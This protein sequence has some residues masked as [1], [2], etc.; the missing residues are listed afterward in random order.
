[1]EDE[2]CRQGSHPRCCRDEAAASPPAFRAR[3]GGQAAGRRAS[4]CILEVYD[5]RENGFL[6]L[7]LIGA[8]TAF[9]RGMSLKVGDPQG[10][11]G[12]KLAAIKAR[13][14][15][16]RSIEM[17]RPSINAGMLRHIEE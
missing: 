15:I 17:L 13:G 8:R 7:P 6:V 1:M 2:P 10:G 14:L 4:K 12:G 11:F 16:R 9:D 5:A 3:L